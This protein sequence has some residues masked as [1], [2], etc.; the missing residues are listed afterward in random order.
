MK[1]NKKSPFGLFLYN[2]G[3]QAPPLPRNAQT[4]IF[5]RDPSTS[6]RMTRATERGIQRGKRTKFVLSNFVGCPLGVV[7]FGQV[8]EAK[9]LV[10][11]HEQRKVGKSARA[12]KHEIALQNIVLKSHKTFDK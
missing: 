3:T 7:S 10:H 6:L 11:L 9:L 8:C 1:K 5:A 4:S 2:G 12:K